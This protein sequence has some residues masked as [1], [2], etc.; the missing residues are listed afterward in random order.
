MKKINFLFAIHCHQPVG[1]FEGVIEE[2]FEKSYLPFIETLEKFHSIKMT[3]HY[4]GILLSWFSEK[5][6]DFLDR[7]KKLVLN[8]QIEIMTGG[9]YEPIISVLPDRDKLGQIKKQ[10]RFLIEKLNCDPSGMWL[11]ERIW[12]PHLPKI[13]KKAGIEYTI[14]D[15]YHFI[16]AGLE[17]SDLDG[18]FITE[19]QGDH[20]KIFPI[21][22]EL[23]YLI[24]F[25]IPQ[26]TIKYLQD[27]ASERDNKAAIIADDGE[28]FGVWP[29]THKWVFEEKWLE[30]FFKE[31]EAN[32]DWIK[33]MTFAEYAKTYPSRGRI[34]VPTA[35]YF[36]M[37]E[38]SL[39]TK[40]GEKLDDVVSDL[41]NSGKFEEYSQFF[42]GGFWRNFFVKYPESNIMHKK[43][44]LVSEKISKMGVH[45]PVLAAIKDELW[46]GQCNC[47]YWHGVFGGLYLNYLRHAIYEHL[48]K[49]ENMADDLLHSD[50]S[51]IE[52]NIFDF[53][54][55]GFDEILVSSKLINVYFAPN[56]GASVFEI[57]FRSRAFNIVNTIAR[58]EEAYHKNILKTDRQSVTKTGEVNGTASIHDI[59]RVKEENLH[60]YL[61]YDWYKKGCF[62][63]HFLDLDTTIDKFSS[64]NYG[65]SGDFVNQG[66]G[67]KKHIKK[68]EVKII[69]E[70]TG[71]VQI[72]AERHPVKIKKVFSVNCMESVITAEYEIKNL[73]NEQL[74]LWFGTEFNLSMLAGDSSDRFYVI[75]GQKPENPKLNSIGETCGIYEVEI[76]DKWTPMGI[77]IES[78]NRSDLWRFPI[79][80]VSQSEGGFERTYQESCL[81]LHRK[82]V[83]DSDAVESF[84]IKLKLT[85]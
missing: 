32:S 23:R 83:L 52:I 60:K 11:A 3:V 66:F 15:D 42:K 73:S 39:L 29:G 84:S 51:W 24:P 65:E 48:I 7:L 47:P 77:I 18:Y 45:E 64:C 54:N 70:R 56:Y 19:E 75:N 21:S 78:S 34:Y 25:R 61:N 63:D 80:T 5:H 81:L 35:S 49:A 12:E 67:F 40:A 2:A 55:D 41:K 36:E 14:L 17:K 4:S 8:G 16:S 31:I 57:D 74:N 27:I 82:I 71:G 72:G 9:Y 85:D 22:K 33:T 30:K 20:V 13:L 59:I 79:E 69:F 50:F 62:I 1:N 43:M 37:M 44:L 10:T 26:E 53:D 38:W 28:K 58:R 76:I 68:N 6:P 46:M